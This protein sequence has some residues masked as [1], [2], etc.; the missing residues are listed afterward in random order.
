MTKNKKV[1]G[2]EM[3]WYCWYQD[4]EKKSSKLEV[5]LFLTMFLFLFISVWF[6]PSVKTISIFILLLMIW[7][8][9]RSSRKDMKA[10]GALF[11]SIIAG[12]LFY[13]LTN[14]SKYVDKL[15]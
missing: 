12:S 10:S 8:F 9:M 14:L 5:I 4:G 6:F 15:R 1:G 11:G 13:I 3:W 7:M 2:G